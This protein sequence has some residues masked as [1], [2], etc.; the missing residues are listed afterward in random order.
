M[1]YW[2]L[3]VA[4]YSSN[5]QLEAAPSMMNL[6]YPTQAACL[7]DAPRRLS[8]LAS[9]DLHGR[10]NCMKHNGTPWDDAR[11]PQPASF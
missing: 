6:H 4:L 3:A 2:F 1:N 11:L 5:G 7:M 8:A 9:I 10:F